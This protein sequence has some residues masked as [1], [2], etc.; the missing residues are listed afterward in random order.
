VIILAGITAGPLMMIALSNSPRAR[1]DCISSQTLP[2]P[3]DWPKMVTWCGSP[4]KA[5]TFRCTHR[6]AAIWSSRP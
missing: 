4:P 2:A 1:G 3:A 6:S 5:A